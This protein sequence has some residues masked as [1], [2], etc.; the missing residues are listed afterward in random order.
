MLIWNRYVIGIPE[1]GIIKFSIIIR[2]LKVAFFCKYAFKQ[3]IDRL[4]V[5]LASFNFC[6]FFLY[7]R[8]ELVII[9]RVSR[10]IDGISHGSCSKMIYVLKI[11]L[12]TPLNTVNCSVISKLMYVLAVDM[13]F[14]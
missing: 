2:N 5:I 10:S 11:I 8:P 13:K 1:D 12:T 7:V 4:E 9:H 3:I 6:S 14:N